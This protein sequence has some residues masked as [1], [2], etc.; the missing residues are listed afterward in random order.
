MNIWLIN[1]YA[2]PPKYY[3][4]ARTTN[5]AKYLM[6]MGH[7]V[8]IFAASSVHNSDL[9]L[10]TDDS[11]YREDTVD[12]I[13]YVYVRCRSYRGNGKQRI[14]NMFEFS[15]RL[16]QVVKHYDRPDA[17][18]ASSATPPACMAGLRIAKKYGARAV[19]E[20]SDL[21]PLSFVDYGMISAKNP[22]LI[23]MYAYEKRMYQYADAV[24]FTMEG[25]YDYIVEKGWDKDIPKEK[26]HYI[27]NGVDL[28]LFRYN[29]EHY[30]I[31]DEDL[32]N[33][34]IFKVV[35]TGSIRKVNNLGLL[36]DAAKEVKD[37]KVKFLV[38]GDGDE[39][40]ALRQRVIDE[41]IQNVVFKGRVEK[42]Y[43]PHIVSESSLNIAHNTPS[44]LFRFGIS[45]NK[46]FD[47]M[48]AEKPILSD[49]PC[50][51]NP[52]EMCGAGR[53][54]EKATAKNIAAEIEYMT[55]LP[56]EKYNE[57][58]NNAALAA[59]KYSFEELTKQLLT[60]I[61]GE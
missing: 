27:N 37:P 50:P 44:L 35:Y 38:W 31:E 49:F 9:N 46:I 23:P 6:R 22:A 10:I 42:K 60:V 59:V 43:V 29:R 39:L 45:F 3:P 20:I 8:T 55:N 40:S 19:A 26:V 11:L 16:P 18:L 30:Q 54:V 1:H 47:Y 61:G 41:D 53:A 52:A 7:T 12:G 34:D 25:A 13:R 4:L 48:A 51:Y 5:F 2:V 33:P 21:W 15:R 58:C 28:E 57:Y 14:I 36:L 17:V 32:N 24:I 56:V